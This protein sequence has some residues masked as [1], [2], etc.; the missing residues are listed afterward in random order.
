L[1]AARILC[2]VFRKS[3]VIARIGGDEFA[4]LLTEQPKADV[5]NVITKHIRDKLKIHNKRISRGYELLFS[6]GVTHYD[7]QYPGS[8]DE[9][10]TRADK[11]MY[12]DK[13]NHKL[14]IS[15]KAAA[16]KHIRPGLA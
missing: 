8:I 10:L 16:K 15:D 11:L 12:A 13:K 6:V 14:K 2:E 5:E 3:D 7:P 4:V 1:D 9:L